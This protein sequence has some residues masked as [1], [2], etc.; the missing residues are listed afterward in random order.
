MSCKY[1]HATR[2]FKTENYRQ[3]KAVDLCLLFLFVC[4]WTTCL[5][6][7]SINQLTKSTHPPVYTPPSVVPPPPASSPLPYGGVGSVWNARFLPLILPSC[8]Y[9][10]YRAIN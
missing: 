8:I 3:R 10:G 4:A 5:L 1:L 6:C 9:Q 7:V 2:H